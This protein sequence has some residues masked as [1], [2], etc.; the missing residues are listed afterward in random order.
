[1]ACQSN[2]LTD[3][4]EPLGRVILIPFDSVPVVHRELMVEVMV[5]LANGNKSGDDV[6]TGCVLIIEWCLAK[7]MGER[8]DTERRLCTCQHG[9]RFI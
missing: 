5:S 8:V 2:I 6:I 3:P 7:P 4:D 1:M 9:G